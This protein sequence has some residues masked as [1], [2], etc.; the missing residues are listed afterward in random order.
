MDERIRDAF[1]S[2]HAEE[3]LKKSTR[4][5]LEQARIRRHR[6][7]RALTAAVACLVLLVVGI[8]GYQFYFTPT[9]VLSID[10]NPSLELGVNRFD[11]VV[12]VQS[13]NE[14]GQALA[15]TLEL[16]YLD[17]RDALEELLASPDI[18]DRLAQGA[19]LSIMVAGENE[20]QCGR[21]LAGAEACTAGQENVSC[22][23]GDSEKLEQAHHAGLSLGKYE[24][25]L[26]LQAL[27]PTVTTDDVAGLTMRQIRDWIASLES[28]GTTAGESQ[29]GHGQPLRLAGIT[30]MGRRSVSPSHFFVF[31]KNRFSIGLRLWYTKRAATIYK[32]LTHPLYSVVY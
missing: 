8:G 11:K 26:E 27:E 32:S 21:L 20:T 15:D 24:A 28:S 9:S 1:A 17:Y 30:E 4:A 6:P 19:L 18:A 12:S 29:T 31:G 14:D 7:A 25:F 10:I 16:K 13:Y 23:H 5:V 22:R 3:E 2:I